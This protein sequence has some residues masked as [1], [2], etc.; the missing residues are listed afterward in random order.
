MT[1]LETTRAM[2]GRP[3]FRLAQNAAT[4]DGA[5]DDSMRHVA[6][7]GWLIIAIFFWRDR[8]LG[9]HSAAQRRGGRQRRSQ[10]RGESQKASSTST[11]GFVKELLVKEGNRVNAGD[12]L[13]V[14]DETQAPGG[15]RC[16]LTT[17]H[18]ASRH[19]STLL[20]RT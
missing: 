14:L 9:C 1:V 12:V 8:I 2:A 11:A 4:S 3:Q 15:V 18:G 17:I 16:T 13:I 19:R 10:G 5:P 20:N 6:L 7:V